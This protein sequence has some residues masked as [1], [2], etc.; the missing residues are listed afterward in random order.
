MEMTEQEAK[1]WV[2]DLPTI[3]RWAIKLADGTYLVN[4]DHSI[5]LMSYFTASGKIQQYP[6]A[7]Q[8]PA[9]EVFSVIK[10][11]LWTMDNSALSAAEVNQTLTTLAS[12]NL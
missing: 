5:K 6:R 1:D 2:M 11:R 9:L 8:F 10:P 3:Y 7:G 4:P 12:D